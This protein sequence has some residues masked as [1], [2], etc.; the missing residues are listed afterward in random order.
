MAPM[1]QLIKNFNRIYDND[2]E[3]DDDDRSVGQLNTL[4]KQP[5][6]IL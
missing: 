5:E 2:D 1:I 6:N 3:D 4:N